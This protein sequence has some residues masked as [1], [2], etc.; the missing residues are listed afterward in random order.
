M[1]NSLV[2][3]PLRSFSSLAVFNENGVGLGM[4]NNNFV[5][6]GTVPDVQ[7]KAWEIWSHVVMFADV[8]ARDQISQATSP[9]MTR[10]PRPSP[11]VLRSKTERGNSLGIKLLND[12]QHVTRS[13]TQ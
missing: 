13:K 8:T 6:L 1:K 3:R 10:S 7:R 4:R 11:S 5:M 2:P 12:M 9:H